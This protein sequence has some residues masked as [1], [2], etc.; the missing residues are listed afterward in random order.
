[1]VAAGTPS[2]SPIRKPAG[3]T[4]AKQAASAL[5]GFQPSAAAHST[6]SAISRRLHRSDAKTHGRSSFSHDC[7]V[8]QTVARFPSRLHGPPGGT[9]AKCASHVRLSAPHKLPNL[10]CR[11][12][13]ASFA[14]RMT[15]VRRGSRGRSE[16][17]G[18]KNPWRQHQ[19]PGHR[20][21][22]PLGGADHRRA[23]R[24]QRVHPARARS[25]RPAA[26]ACCCTTGATPAPP[27][28]CST[29]T[30]SRRSPGPTT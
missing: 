23:A 30:R 12:P 19:L 2:I 15:C 6:A 14:R 11:M 24:A 7:E 3:S 4:V 13:G 10:F 22:R 1:M 20:R 5:P 9:Q 21:A 29:A 16:N 25:S 28:S 17:A 27:T 18:R 26:T 8:S